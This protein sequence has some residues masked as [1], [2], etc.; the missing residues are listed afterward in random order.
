MVAFSSEVRLPLPYQRTQS[1]TM[2]V[3]LMS[4]L[5]RIEVDAHFEVHQAVELLRDAHVH[6]NS[7]AL[8][9][10]TRARFGIISV[11]REEYAKALELLAKAGIKATPG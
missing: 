4:R 6:V 2:P 10:S 7:G 9:E 11:E 3:T 5:I 1:D 8:V